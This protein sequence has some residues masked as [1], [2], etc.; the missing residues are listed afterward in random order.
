ME[1]NLEDMIIQSNDEQLQLYSEGHPFTLKLRIKSFG[2][3]AEQKKFI[4][5]VESLVRRS[6][7]YRLWKNYIID[8]LQ[9]NIC[10]I[11][12]EKIDEVSLEVH[13][14]IP[15]LFVLVSAILNKKMDN[16][17]E[18]STF[19]V[20]VDAI[21]LHFKNMIGYTLLINTMHEKFHAGYLR[22]PIELIKGNYQRFLDD[23]SKYIDEE[24][25]EKI[26]SKLSIKQ[27]DIKDDQWTKDQYPGITEAVNGWDNND[28][29]RC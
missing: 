26:L 2:N 14:H 10:S 1:E 13:H 20:A 29:N 7:E 17:E 27:C 15:S 24:D 8:V 22:V 11:T 25:L 3:E 23:Y 12:K 9:I 21:E 4:K 18:F 19:D 16:D 28:N 5:N 6:I